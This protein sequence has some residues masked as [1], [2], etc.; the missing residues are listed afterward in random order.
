MASYSSFKGEVSREKRRRHWG[1][2]AKTRKLSA[3]TIR[4]A[5]R[6]EPTNAIFPEKRGRR[7]RKKKTP[8]KRKTT[9]IKQKESAGE[10]REKTKPERGRKSKACKV[11]P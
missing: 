1:I 10:P 4:G 3:T 8:G 6:C 5:Q 11:R 9:R 2:A 7:K